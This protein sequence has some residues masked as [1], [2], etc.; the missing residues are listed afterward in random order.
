LD[1]GGE[2]LIALETKI[3]KTKQELKNK[4]AEIDKKITEKITELRKELKDKFKVDAST[5]PNFG[6]GTDANDANRLTRQ[7]H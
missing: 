6:S 5:A 1:K 3:D 2:E 7:D 4:E